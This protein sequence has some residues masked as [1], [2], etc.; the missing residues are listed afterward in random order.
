MKLWKKVLLILVALGFISGGTVYVLFIYGPKH[1]FDI[2]KRD[3]SKEQGIVVGAD[4]LTASFKANKTHWDSTFLDK[5]V[6]IT[7]TVKETKTDSTTTITIVGADST[8]TIS[9]L[10]QKVDNSVKAG[11]KATLKGICKGGT[12]DD[13]FGTAVQVNEAIIIKH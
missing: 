3:P 1:G 7:G 6:E 2:L 13:L 4:E 5:T 9:C 8:A 11:D 10:C 12:S